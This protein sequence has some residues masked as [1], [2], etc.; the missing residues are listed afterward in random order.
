M[1]TL[2][3]LLPYIEQGNLYNS[4]P[5]QLFTPNI[6]GSWWGYG[7]YNAVPGGGTHV[8]T[9]ECPADAPYAYTTGMFAFFTEQ[10]SW[11]GQNGYAFTGV[12]FPGSGGSVGLGATNY[13]PTAAPW[14][15]T[16]NSGTP[17]TAPTSGRTPITRKRN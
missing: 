5:Q 7:N 1:G 17:S 6:G 12:Y 11:T 8:K 2:P 4:L 13:L 9:F 14:G 15:T 3:W 10:P 16:R